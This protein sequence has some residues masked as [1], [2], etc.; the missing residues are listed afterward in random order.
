MKRN[1]IKNLEEYRKKIEA[2][3]FPKTVQL[4][5]EELCN[6]IAYTRSE[7]EK[8]KPTGKQIL[9][10]SDSH[11]NLYDL[12]LNAW[13][14]GFMS[15]FKNG[16]RSARKKLLTGDRIKVLRKKPDQDYELI[17]IEN[18]LT[19]LQSEVGGYIECV[20]LTKDSCIVCNEEGLL[21]GLPYNTDINGNTY[22]GTILIVGV[23]GEDLTDIPEWKAK[24]IEKLYTPEEISSILK[25][26]KKGKLSDITR[27][28]ADKMISRR[29]DC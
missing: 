17:E 25:R 20:S 14:A 5:A 2:K 12:V 28:Q 15:G 13:S 27:A 22:T 6:L 8:P 3:Q 29:T 7:K 10:K 4:T 18:T 21:H 11:D 24:E 16:A 1:I 9:V 23:K 19:A 26:L